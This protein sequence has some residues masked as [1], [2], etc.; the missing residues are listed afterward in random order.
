MSRGKNNRRPINKFMEN[1]DIN[2]FQQNRTFKQFTFNISEGMVFLTIY[3][4]HERRYGF[5]NNLH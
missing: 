5:S 4:K 2:S 3:S 1:K